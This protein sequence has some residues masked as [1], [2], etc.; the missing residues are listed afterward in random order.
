MKKDQT[1]SIG[2]IGCGQWG[3]NHIRN[4]STMPGSRVIAAADPARS[5]LASL[6]GLYPSVRFTTYGADILQDKT[7]DAVVVSTPTQTHGRIA[8]EALEAG[9]HVLVEKPLCTTAAE[10][11]KLVAL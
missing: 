5:R 8:G 3:P 11:E 10:G 6:K 7:I 4:F 1:I 9:K 2:V